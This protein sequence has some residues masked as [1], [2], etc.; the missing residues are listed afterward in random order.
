MAVFSGAVLAMRVPAPRAVH[1]S[2]SVMLRSE[3]TPTAVLYRPALVF[4]LARA[5]CPSAV[6]PPG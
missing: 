3:Y 4:R 2:P 6:L 1:K 5:S